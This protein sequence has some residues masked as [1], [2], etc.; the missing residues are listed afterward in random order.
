[1]MSRRIKLDRLDPDSPL[2]KKIREALKAPVTADPAFG[3]TEPIRRAAFETYDSA[4]EAEFDAWCQEAVQLGLASKVTYHPP[5]LE[6]AP[7]QTYEKV[8]HMKT[9]TKRVDAFLLHPH[10][11]TAD[12]TLDLTEVGKVFLHGRGLLY[13]CHID[14][15]MWIDV[16]GGFS[17][18]HDEKQFVI[19]QK[20]V[21][22]KFEVY[23]HKVIPRKWFLKTWVP[24]MAR[25]SPKKGKLRNCYAKCKVMDDIRKELGINGP[26][27]T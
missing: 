4:E 13:T 11:Y 7:R 26:Q 8:V 27:A 24:K 9:K 15:I 10:S 5:S 16:K 2:A 18:Y 23:V 12:F 21:Y 3:N 17:P 19:N 1:M 25:T 6:L 14:D 20:W 22:D